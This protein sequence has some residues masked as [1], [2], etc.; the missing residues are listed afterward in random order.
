MGNIMEAEAVF[1]KQM[2]FHIVIAA[3]TTS[4]F[5]LDLSRKRRLLIY[6]YNW[7]SVHINLSMPR[8]FGPFSPNLGIREQGSRATRYI[9]GIR[10]LFFKN[11]WKIF[12]QF[13]DSRLWDRNGWP[14]GDEWEPSKT[15]WKSWLQLTAPKPSL[16][17]VK[18]T[19][20]NWWHALSRND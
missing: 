7:I 12:D 19:R 4:R 16:L 11:I 14:E 1:T 9:C 6:C 15:Q 10:N 13:Q 20:V 18:I 3:N 5:F 17:I 2:C 8:C